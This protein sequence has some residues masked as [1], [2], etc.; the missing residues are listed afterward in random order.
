MKKTVFTFGRMNPPTVGHEKLVAKVNEVAKR[1]KATPLVYLSHTQNKKKDPLSYDQKIKFATKS[2]GKIVV[3]SRS[4]TIIQILQE[5]ESKKYTDITMVVG[6]DRVEDFKGL[7]NKYNG[8]DYTFNSIEIVSAGARD[9]DAEGVEGMSASKMRS[10]VADGEMEEFHTGAPSKLSYKDAHSM[11]NDLRKG[12]MLED[13]DF[14]LDIDAFVEQFNVDSYDLEDLD[15]AAPMT[16]SQRL[17]RARQMKR[18][19]PRFKNLRKIKAKRMADPARL[20]QRAQKQAKNIIRKRMAGEKGAKYNTL[21]VAAKIAIDKLTLT[22]AP[23]IKMLAKRL[24]PK[25]RQAEMQRLKKARSSKKESYDILGFNGLN[26]DVTQKQ[27]NDLEKFADRLLAKF[28]IDVEFTRH[29]ADRMN[30]SRNSPEIKVSELQ[31]F[32]KKIAKNK[33]KNIRQNADAEVVLK[34][35]QADL[36]LPVVIKYDKDKQDFEVINKTI[37]RK[38]DFKTTSKTIQYEGT[39]QALND[40]FEMFLESKFSNAEKVQDKGERD[41]LRAKHA[42]ERKR[43]K[44]THD[45]DMDQ[46]RSRDTRTVNRSTRVESLDLLDEGVNDPGIFKAVFLAGG[47]GSGKSFVV[48]KTALTALGLKLINSDSA[49]EKYLTKADLTFDPDD[50]MSDEGQAARAK[51]KAVT[52]LKLKGAINGRLGLVIDGTGKDFAKIIRQAMQLKILGYEVAMIFVNTDLETALDRNANRPRTLPDDKVT[53]MW[54]DVQK[55][56]G[57]FQNYFSDKFVVLDNSSDANIEGAVK[58]AYNKMSKWI[59]L[60]PKTPKSKMWIKSAK[61]ARGITEQVEQIDELFEKFTGNDKFGINR[62]ASKTLKKKSYNHAAQTLKDLISRKKKEKTERHGVLYYA[63]KV[64]KSYAGVDARTLANMVEGYTKT[65][66]ALIKKA[67]KHHIPLEVVEE[68]YDR[69]MVAYGGETDIDQTQEQYAFSRLNSFIGGGK[70]TTI[71]YDIDLQPYVEVDEEKFQPHMMYDPKTGEGKKAYVKKDH[72][73]MKAKGWGHDKPKVKEDEAGGA[74][75]FGTDKLKK[76]YEK[77]TPGEK[78]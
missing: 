18:M 31:R 46:A 63:A 35:M 54:K 41:R 74:G 6:S 60:P 23:A 9:P 3:K 56:I 7:L 13:L 44:E 42:A 40:S 51:A 65:E 45:D 47:P 26:E 22:K 17:K 61:Q 58:S 33:G 21:S 15:E 8:K 49:F 36:N 69:G 77:D 53:E 29:F 1:Q 25:V 38:K 48:G 28:D 43:Q 14:K 52:G 57:K 75:E 4:K 73:A 32:F 2:F 67:L 55:N 64:A 12:M 39:Q 59:K 68:V 24:L 78:K 66:E 19:A 5:L 10:L 11:Y 72:L 50:I 62:F 16:M 20:I 27:I 71:D 76:K 37:M 34:D 70:A 30:D